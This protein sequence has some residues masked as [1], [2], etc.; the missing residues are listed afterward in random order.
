MV[1]VVMV[2]V[3]VMMI[4]SCTYVIIYRVE[5]T[6]YLSYTRQVI[7]YDLLFLLY[8]RLMREERRRLYSQTSH[9]E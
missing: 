1:M 6:N 9:S 5:R 3:M 8:L 7:R 2:M 4:L